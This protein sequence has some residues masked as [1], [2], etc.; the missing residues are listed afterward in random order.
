MPKLNSPTNTAQINQRTTPALSQQSAIKPLQWT[1]SNGQNHQ[2]TLQQL[3]KWFA[4]LEKNDPNRPLSNKKPNTL[5]NNTLF[6]ADFLARFG[7]QASNIMMFLQ[8][9]AATP[10]LSLYTEALHELAEQEEAMEQMAIQE[11][12]HQRYRRHAL[13]LLALLFEQ[14]LEAYEQELANSS[15]EQFQKLQ[16]VEKAHRAAEANS[17]AGSHEAIERQI[18]EHMEALEAL[19]EK[20]SH[21]LHESH[22]IDS[23]LSDFETEKNNLEAEFG[24]YSKQLVHLDQML[25]HA[26]AQDNPKAAI[27]QHIQELEAAMRQAM[28]S[29]AHPT[30][31]EEETKAHEVPSNYQT[32]HLR[33]MGLQDMLAVH[34]G[35]KYLVDV[36]GKPAKTMAQAHFV[37]PQDKKIVQDS[38]GISY[39]I[40]KH[41]KLESLQ[42]AAD[43]KLQLALAHQ[44]YQKACQ[45]HLSVH[46]QL[47]THKQRKTEMFHENHENKYQQA[48][49]QSKTLQL[50]ILLLSQQANKLKIAQEKLAQKLAAS[51]EQRLQAAPTPKPTPQF[52]KSDETKHP[53][54]H[55]NFAQPSPENTLSKTLQLAFK[56]MLHHPTPKNIEDFK[57][58]LKIYRNPEDP[59][60]NAIEKQLRALQ[61]IPTK[62]P[63]PQKMIQDILQMLDQFAHLD[64]KTP[65]S[66]APNPFSTRMDKMKPY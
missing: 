65:K 25:Q 57:Q 17:A 30:T 39:L 24:E 9:P 2:L 54:S 23:L 10:I 48:L 56:L 29:S 52:R 3:E 66:T 49:T 7:L 42:T 45:N 59:L 41:E 35:E 62:T 14:D 38:Q 21:K 20:I 63:V 26:E 32:N 50:E 46:Q 6:A 58:R 44:A 53:Q 22:Q 36:T 18:N 47:A 4:T 27:E 8:S 55:F 51:I 60:V 1:D 31:T 16:A 19:S 40:P 12:I 28:S 43:G 37:L 64:E 13:F 61:N 33:L 34:R 5:E 11:N 15:E